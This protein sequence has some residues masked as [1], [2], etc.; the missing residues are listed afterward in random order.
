MF[1]SS[2]WHF[3]FVFARLQVQKLGPKNRYPDYSLFSV[4]LSKWWDSA[5]KEAI[6]AS[7]L[8]KSL[9]LTLR[10]KWS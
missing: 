3:C 4:I 7:F 9:L 6:T 2:Y 5:L 10:N 8:Y 1:W